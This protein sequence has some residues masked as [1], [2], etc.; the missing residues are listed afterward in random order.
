[1]SSYVVTCCGHAVALLMD[2][3]PEGGL[4][5]ESDSSAIVIA[6]EVTIDGVPPYKMRPEEVTS[7]WA[8]HKTTQTVWPD[9]HMSWTIRCECSRQ[10]EFSDAN[11]RLI[12]DALKTGSQHEVPL[13]VLC[14]TLRRFKE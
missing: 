2:A 1:M 3:R 5:V 4:S 6:G 14:N 10:A 13:G 8:E 12:A 11:F 9:G 7:N